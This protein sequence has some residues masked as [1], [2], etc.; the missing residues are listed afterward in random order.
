MQEFKLTKSKLALFSIPVVLCLII[1]MV[2]WPFATSVTMSPRSDGTFEFGI[3]ILFIL[4]FLLIAGV[5]FISAVCLIFRPL[6][7][8]ALISL[9]ICLASGFS[10]VVG[11]F[12]GGSISKH[13][14]VNALGQLA[15]RSKPLIVAIKSYEQKFGHPPNSLDALVPEFISKVPTT[16]IGARPNYEFESLTNNSTYGKNPW[17]LYVN[18]PSADPMSFDCFLYLP[19]Q[20]YSA[21][22]HQFD[23]DIRKIGDWAYWHRG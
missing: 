4:S 2:A 18:N 1:P 9:L 19:L 13:I 22:S 10:F 15:E 21:L 8:I 14:Q 5:F 11:L 20:D 3:G 7:L 17:V 16:G 12:A 6:R 23:N